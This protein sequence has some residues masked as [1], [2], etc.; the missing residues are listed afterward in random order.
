[1]NF[2]ISGQKIEIPCKTKYLWLLLDANLN[3]KS[4]IDSL[5]TKLR[6]ANCL[7][8]KIRHYVSKDLLRTIYYA[9]FDS[10]GMAAKFEVNA[11]LNP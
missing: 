6:Q 4:H 7:L 10:Q 5:K 1:M 8:F 2:R 11:K 3:F 9:L